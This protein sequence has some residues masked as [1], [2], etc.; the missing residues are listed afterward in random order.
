LK[1][2]LRKRVATLTEKHLDDIKTF[3]LKVLYLEEG[4]SN[5]STDAKAELD[6][7]N[8]E[9]NDLQMIRPDLKKSD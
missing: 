8:A 7:A 9:K 5:L 4:K 2:S 3:T 1:N 6:K